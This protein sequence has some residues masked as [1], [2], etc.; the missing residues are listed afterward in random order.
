MKGSDAIGLGMYILY[1]HV[2]YR[3]LV[4]ISSCVIVSL[5]DGQSTGMLGLYFALGLVLLYHSENNGARNFVSGDQVN[6]YKK[7]I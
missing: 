2:I 7:K 6:I 1:M 5:D 4:T 3:L